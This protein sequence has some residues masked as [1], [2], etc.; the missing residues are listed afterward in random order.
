MCIAKVY[1][2]QLLDIYNKINLDIE[3]LSKQE[4]KTTLYDLDMLHIIE[5][6]N[7]N[8]C[9]GYKLAKKIQINRHKRRQIKNE[10]DTLIQLKNNFI[11]QN[12]GILSQ[13]YNG[14]INRDNYLNQLVDTK[15]YTPKII[16]YKNLKPYK[17]QINIHQ[18]ETYI[19]L[20][21]AIHKKTKENLQV[22]SK[23]DDK[24][25]FVKRKD[26]RKEVLCKKNILNFEYLQ[27]AK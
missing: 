24:H 18:E 6:T 19:I 21:N 17:E 3:I 7:F 20:G 23:I 26:G 9:E 25:Y 14:I 11:D 4:K 27:S 12:I 10:L 13:T 1:T 22:L 16:K 2:E 5:N 15:A 8:A